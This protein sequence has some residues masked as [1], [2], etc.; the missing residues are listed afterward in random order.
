ML[1]RAWLFLGLIVA[2]LSLAGFFDVLTQAGWHSGDRTGAHTCFQ[3]AYLQATT[4]TFLGV[5]FGQIGPAFA[6]PTRRASLRSVG[7]FSNRYLLYGDRRR[8]R[9]RRRVR[10]CP[11][12]SSAARHRRPT[13]TRHAAA[14][15]VPIHRLGRRRSASGWSGVGPRGARRP[16]TPAPA[17]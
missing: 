7:V 11:T 9:D 10:V 14:Y 5:I 16:V 15:P 4:M 17:A 12:V 13:R 6:V 8:A 2:I 1:I 3:H